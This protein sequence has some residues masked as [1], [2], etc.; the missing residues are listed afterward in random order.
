MIAGPQQEIKMPMCDFFF[1]FFF[2]LRNLYTARKLRHEL[3]CGVNG[4]LCC[5]APV[6]IP[7][8]T[9]AFNSNPHWTKRI[10]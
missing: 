8:R 2:F 10:T 6:L 5:R 4:T 7:V 9:F 1:F 3:S